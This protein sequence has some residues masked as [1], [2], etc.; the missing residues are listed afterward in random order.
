M[1]ATLHERLGGAA[2]IAAVVDDAIDRHAVDPVL[3]PRLQGRDLPRLKQLAVQLLCTSVLGPPVGTGIALRRAIAALDLGE[4]EWAAAI[5]GIVA[6][7]RERGVGAAEVDAVVGLL[8]AA[9]R[10]VLPA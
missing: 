3:A 10:A 4:H 1:T 7:M 5:D 9:R 2:G 6:A 8:G